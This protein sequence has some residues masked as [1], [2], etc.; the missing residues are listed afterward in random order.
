MTTTSVLTPNMLPIARRGVLRLAAIVLAVALVCSAVA[1]AVGRATAHH[2][3]TTVIAPAAQSAPTD[4][5]A[6]CTTVRRAC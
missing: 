3:T 6:Q 5:P 1:F 2:H 4:T